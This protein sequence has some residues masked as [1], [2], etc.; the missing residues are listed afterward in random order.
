MS[1]VS[2]E[3]LDDMRMTP[4]QEIAHIKENIDNAPEDYFGAVKRIM[5]LEMRLED[6]SRAVEIAEITG[7]LN[8]VSGFRTAADECLLDKKMTIKR[9]PNGD[10]KLTVITGQL[11]PTL[12]GQVANSQ[13][14][15][16]I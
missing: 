14:P 7:Q 9:E 11:D 3:V 8:L 16:A 10:M 5:E 4:E 12:A 13:Q 2:N 6:L 1:E 15:Q